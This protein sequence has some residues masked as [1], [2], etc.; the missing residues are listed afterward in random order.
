M[1]TNT[2]TLASELLNQ[3][4]TCWRAAREPGA[5]IPILDIPQ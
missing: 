1:T 4:D 5:A 3:M 2:T